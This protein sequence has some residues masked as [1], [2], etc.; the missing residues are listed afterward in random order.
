MRRDHITD[1]IDSKETSCR[2]PGYNWRPP[3]VGWI[4]TRVEAIATRVKTI[5]IRKEAIALLQAIPIYDQVLCAAVKYVGILCLQRREYWLGDY[6]LDAG[7]TGR[8]AAGSREHLVYSA[9]R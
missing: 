7:Y 2:T 6:V 4:A 3:L 5:A 1:H 9:L 8:I